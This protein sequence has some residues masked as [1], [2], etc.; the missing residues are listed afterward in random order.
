MKYGWLFVSP[1]CCSSSCNATTILTAFSSALTPMASPGP[2]GR[3]ESARLPQWVARPST[4]IAEVPVARRDR[5]DGQRVRDRRRLGDDGGV[6]GEPRL[7]HRGRA[8]LVLHRLLADDGVQEKVALELDVR[9]GECLG[10]KPHRGVRPLHVRRP[11]SVEAVVP[12]LGVPRVAVDPIVGIDGR[13]RV[14]VAVESKS[15]ATAAR[16]PSGC[17]RGSAAPGSGAT[18]WVSSPACSYRSRRISFARVSPPITSSRLTPANSG[19]TL[20]TRTSSRRSSTASS[21]RASTH[22]STRS[23]SSAIRSLPAVR[24]PVSA[25]PQASVRSARLACSPVPCAGCASL[26]DARYELLDLRSPR[27]GALD[28]HRLGLTL[29]GEHP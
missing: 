6:G 5:G 4:W 8:E 27:I 20:F 24:S 11:D 10:D 9:I 17:R 25:P 12:D 19:L 23:R 2:P 29:A 18:Q 22:A 14:H 1:H 28:G 13:D 3:I 16:G 7:E 26:L 21:R 15:A